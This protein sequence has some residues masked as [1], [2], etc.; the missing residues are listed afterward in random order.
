MKTGLTFS[1]AIQ[2]ITHFSFYDNVNPNQ[3]LTRTLSGRPQNR[4]LFLWRL[5]PQRSLL[6]YY[7]V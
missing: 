1:T 3:I 2:Y 5:A 6:F 7:Y 4:S